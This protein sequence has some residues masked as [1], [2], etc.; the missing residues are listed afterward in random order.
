MKRLFTLLCILCGALMSSAQ[1]GDFALHSITLPAQFSQQII[2]CM[3]QD[4]LGMFWFVTNDGLFRFDGNEVVHLGPES[5]PRIPHM[6]IKALFRDKKGNMWIGAQDGITCLNLHN[7]STK[8]IKSKKGLTALS[9]YIKVIGE[10]SDGMIYAGSQNGRVYKVQNDSLVCI[11]DMNKSFD[12]L[13]DLPNITFIHAPVSGQLWMGTSVGRIII[14]DTHNDG[15]YG[16][17]RFYGLDAFKKEQITA[18]TFGPKGNCILSVSN[19]GLY[20]LNASTGDL[21]KLKGPHGDLGKYG[22][23][24]M[25]PLNNHQTIIMTNTPGIGKE[26]LFLYDFETDS[27]TVRDLHFPRYLEDNH[28]V[29]LSHTG[30]KVLLSLNDQVMELAHSN[31]PFNAL[32]AEPKSLN[33]IRAVYK[34]PG[35]KLL[36]GSYKDGFVS[37]DEKTGDRKVVARKYVYSIIPWN[38]DSVVLSTEGD[39]LFWYEI[40]KNKLTNIEIP[41]QNIRG[42]PM[43]TFLTFLL[44]FDASHLLVGTYERL[45]MVNPY[46]HRAHAIREDRL[47][48]TRVLNILKRREDYLVATEHGVLKWNSQTDSI[49]DFRKPN[50]KNDPHKVMVYGMAIVNDLVWTATNGYGIVIYDKQGNAVDTISRAD[51]LAA[52]IVFTIAATDKYVLAGTKSGLSVINKETHHITNYSTVDQLPA[53]EFN[54]SAVYQRGNSV[55]FGTIDG[56][57]RFNTDKLTE[58]G[59]KDLQGN[60]YITDLAITDKKG[61]TVNDYT[62][63]YQE[64]KGFSI[65]SGTAYFSIGF[66]SMEQSMQNLDYYYRLDQTQQW[67]SVGNNRKVTFIGMPPGHYQME[68]VAKLPDGNWTRPLL[69]MPVTVA[70]AFYQTIWFKILIALCVIV[71]LWLFIKYRE[72]EADKERALRLQIAGD[73]HDE[74]GS[75]LAGM[76]M[77]AEM[78][79]SG[80]QEHQKSYLKSIADNG[81]AAVQTMGDIVWSIDPRNDDSLSLFQRMERYGNKILGDSDIAIRLESKGFTDKQYIPQKIRQNVMLIYKEA[82]TNIIKHS[83]A[84]RIVVQFEPYNKG[85]KLFVTDNG[86][87]VNGNLNNDK[88][89]LPGHGLRNMEMRAKLI[90]ADLSF[91]KVDQGF[92]IAL[93]FKG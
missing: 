26:K 58:Y 40:A 27:I 92:K 22:Q 55:Y 65:P 67:I 41:A 19:F 86:K 28:I 2:T 18:A 76:S 47:L 87:G 25:A 49:S 66:G 33:S 51:G 93:T 70:P 62:L 10:G 42:K 78:L 89:N 1:K 5:T 74:I 50:K 59:S 85:F 77:Q 63:P 24:F 82:L 68:L 4:D 91:P 20:Y 38:K 56:V 14:I 80:H 44:R 35:G 52:G 88:A 17:P 37:Y 15:T 23:V 29:W 79:L 30:S 57:V 69:S 90:E 13:Y 34:Q 31:S 81:R 16:N 32:M 84:N 64:N 72:H 46:T 11:F 3:E 54:S 12:D 43:G 8:E 45:Y 39:G 75:T 48:K 6:D 9:L 71:L 73:L 61:N 60:L 36:A 21:H 83:G 7:W 53:N